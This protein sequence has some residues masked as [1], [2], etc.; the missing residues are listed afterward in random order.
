[1][2]DTTPQ[3]P[4]RTLP[5]IAQRRSTNPIPRRDGRPSTNVTQPRMPGVDTAG[6]GFRAGAAGSKR[7]GS[8]QIA[9]QRGTITN[10]SGYAQRDQRLQ[11]RKA[12]L[13]QRALGKPSG[14]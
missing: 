2:R 10:T 1:M 4:M 7:Y 5:V 6:G 13:E 14:I 3:P 12:A 11:A 8:G 9:P